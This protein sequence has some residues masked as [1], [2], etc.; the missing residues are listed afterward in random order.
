LLLPIAV[1]VFLFI[2]ADLFIKILAYSDN[3]GWSDFLRILIFLMMA[4]YYSKS[5][6]NTFIYFIPL[7]IAVYFVGGDRVNMIGYMFFLY[8]ALQYRGG[9]NIGILITTLYFFYI[10]IDFV[11]KIILY[12][13]GF[14]P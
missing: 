8:S 5:K 12:G 2:Q 14:N 11:R 10:N 7:F 1:V 4:L 9:F 3:R 13:N 6:L